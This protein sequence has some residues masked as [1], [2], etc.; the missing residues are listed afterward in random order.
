[1]SRGRVAQHRSVEYL[2]MQCNITLRYV[3][4]GSGDGSRRRTCC[5]NN[6]LGTYPRGRAW[7]KQNRTERNGSE[8]NETKRNETKRNTQSHGR[9]LRVG[10]R[11][12]VCDGIT[13]GVTAA[14]RPPSLS[15]SSECEWDGD[16]FRRSRALCVATTAA[17]AAPAAR[18]AAAL[19]VS[20]KAA[21]LRRE[22][23]R[24]GHVAPRLSSLD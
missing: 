5:V 11:A 24:R 22:V 8:R 4:L 18:S 20:E 7:R 19:C 17:S 21:K 2:S 9:R 14:H 16:D 10:R 6:H 3:T 12:M 23:R 15:P 13:K 1:M